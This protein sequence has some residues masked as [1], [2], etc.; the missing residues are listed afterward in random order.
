METII[1]V[2]PSELNSTLLNKIKKFIGKKDNID[3]IISLREFDRVYANAL[4]LSVEQ[5]EIGDV[6]SMTMEEFVQYSPEKEQ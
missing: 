4:D 5:A 3:V 2:N 6:V 1:K